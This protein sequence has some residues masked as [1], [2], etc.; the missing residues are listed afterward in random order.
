MLLTDTALFLK[1]RRKHRK[2]AVKITSPK[3]IE[4]YEPIFDSESRKLLNAIIE[5]A[6]PDWKSPILVDEYS[7]LFT[8]S[9]ILRV[10]FGVN[11]QG[12]ED[13]VFQENH[14]L[15]RHLVKLT[16]PI[17]ALLDFI[18]AFRYIP[19]PPFSSII[20]MAHDGYLYAE[21]VWGGLV[22]DM[23]DRMHAGTDVPICAA[24]M[25]LEDKEKEELDHYDCW[26]LLG[27]MVSGGVESVS[28]SSFL[29]VFDNYFQL[30]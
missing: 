24:R 20:K 21:R 27:T 1:Y 23:E 30:D 15:L 22:K 14:H 12:M 13:P 5:G 6:G 3:A 16:N 25:V 29:K 19:I 11:C 28:K 26:S 10:L 8:F 9:T 7:N 4:S 18:P 2:L 17:G